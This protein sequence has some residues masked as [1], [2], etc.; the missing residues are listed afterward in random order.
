M[1]MIDAFS[2]WAFG[3]NRRFGLV[4]SVSPNFGFHKTSTD[5]FEKKIR[6]RRFRFRF[7][8]SV[9]WFKLKKIDISIAEHN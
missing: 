2:S 8:S 1:I 3:L 5:R 9:F 4:F 6:N 7:F